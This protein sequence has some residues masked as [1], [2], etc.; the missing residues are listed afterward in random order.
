MANVAVIVSTRRDGYDDPVFKTFLATSEKI[1]LKPFNMKETSNFLIGRYD[2]SDIDP[3]I[4][5]F[6]HA[7][8][9]GVAATIICLL[10]S[11]IE[12]QIFLIDDERVLQMNLQKVQ[13]R[14]QLEKL[15]VRKGEGRLYCAPAEA[16]L[17]L[18]EIC[19]VFIHPDPYLALRMHRPP[20]LCVSS[21]DRRS[22]S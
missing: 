15:E 16:E 3:D 5:S 21:S 11:L 6:C 12:S 22:Q 8:A 10:D 14:E 9:H 1:S 7:R 20:I 18:T 17:Q 2:L 13:S 4:L 19:S